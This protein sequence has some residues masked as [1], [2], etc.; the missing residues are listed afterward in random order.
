M[1]ISN[2][3]F[4]SL[5]A[6][7]YKLISAE[8]RPTLVRIFFYSVILAGLEVVS[9]AIVFPLLQI[10]ITDAPSSSILG[11]SLNIS[12]DSLNWITILTGIVTLYIVK[13]IFA[14]WTNHNQSRFLDRLYLRYSHQIYQEF[15][16]QSWTD[17]TKEN[18]SEAFRK[19]K[20]TAYEFA[21][22]VLHNYLFLLPEVL[23]CVLMLGVV[24]WIDYRILFILFLLFLPILI[25]YYFFRRNVIYKLD[26]SFRDLTPQASIILSQGID[27]FAEAR[28]YRKENYFIEHFIA[29]SEI[30]THQLSRL[31]T[32]TNLPLRLVETIGILCFAGI[33]AYGKVYPETKQ[34]LLLFWSCSL[35]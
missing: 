15:Y 33:I 12:G 31:K 30:T 21:H 6:Q 27:S 28:M 23:V 4:F 19:I 14:L 32:F 18:S 22:N 1:K 8:Q 29:I 34:S 9:L 3:S 7:I 25:F 10:L 24:V 20:N 35:W 26:K 2:Q 17:F 16:R 13:N 11:R 5:S